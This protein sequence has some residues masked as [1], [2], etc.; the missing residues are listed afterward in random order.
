MAAPTHLTAYCPEDPE[1]CADDYEH[2]PDQPQDG[3]AGQ[4]PDQ[5]QYEP[6]DDHEVTRPSFEW[7]GTCVFPTPPST[8]QTDRRARLGR[9]DSGTVEG[10]CNQLARFAVE[11]D[12]MTDPET[13]ERTAGGPLGYVLGKAKSALGAV[14]G[15]EDLE[16]EGNLQQAQVEAEADAERERQAAELRKRE[17]E[18]QEERVESAAERDRLRAELEADERKRHIEELEDQRER[19][20]AAAAAERQRA[21]DAQLQERERAAEL[22]EAEALRRRAADAESVARLQR[23]AATAERSADIIDPEVQ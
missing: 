19:E 16:R 17:V 2:H 6:D 3:N 21:I 20:V 5:Q 23:E 14:L 18:V 11:D 8:Q 1:D 10:R 9:R 7:V 12:E 4:E 13:P 22:A 15:R